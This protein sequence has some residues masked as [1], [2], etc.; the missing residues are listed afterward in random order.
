MGH[1]GCQ[2]R[3]LHVGPEPEALV[4][5]SQEREA[6]TLVDRT[7]NVVVAAVGVPVLL[8]TPPECSAPEQGARA[9]VLPRAP[10]QPTF[11]KLLA[12]ENSKLLKK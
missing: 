2:L 4:R 1:D 9:P 5:K 3:M 12:M 7:E 10:S 8:P 6:E 11:T